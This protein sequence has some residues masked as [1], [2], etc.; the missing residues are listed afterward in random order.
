MESIEPTACARFL[1]LLHIR[2]DFVAILDSILLFITFGRCMTMLFISVYTH[3]I[4]IYHFMS[5]SILRVCISFFPWIFV[6]FCSLPNQIHFGF[7]FYF[8]Y[9]SLIIFVSRNILVGVVVQVDRTILHR[10]FDFVH[11][12]W[13]N[14]QTSW[15]LSNFYLVCALLRVQRV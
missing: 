1:P 10:S 14:S 8:L 2:Y 7:S 4:F 6:S 13:F 12:D 3:R 5:T 11:Y 15:F 9:F